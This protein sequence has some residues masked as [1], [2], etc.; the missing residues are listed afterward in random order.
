MGHSHQRRAMS[1]MQPLA[2]ALLVSLALVACGGASEP[3]SNQAQPAVAGSVATPAEATPRPAPIDLPGMPALDQVVVSTN[4]P[5]W[6]AAIEGDSVEFSVMGEHTRTLAIASRQS[7]GDTWTLQAS[8][9]QGRLEIVVK[10]QP[11]QDSMSGAEY[12]MWGSI[13]FDDQQAVQGCA[14]P[15][16]MPPPREPGGDD[17]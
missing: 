14:R 17:R 5:F 15:A 8:D 12:P 10:D 7:S 2:S 6:N 11:C 4:E 3:D 1:R 16:S 13:A 9:A